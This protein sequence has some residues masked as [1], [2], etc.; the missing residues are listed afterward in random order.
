[1][2]INEWGNAQ[3]ECVCLYVRERGRVR[4]TS[5]YSSETLQNEWKRK[6]MKRKKYILKKITA[7]DIV[8]WIRKWKIEWRKKTKR[9]KCLF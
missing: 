2:W 6:W 4:Q 3:N 9:E 1:M 8:Q 5:M 7:A